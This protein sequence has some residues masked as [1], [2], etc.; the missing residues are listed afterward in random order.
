MLSAGVTSSIDQI[1]RSRKARAGAP[2]RT[3]EED[4][5]VNSIRRKKGSA[6][7][8][9]NSFLWPHSEECERDGCGCELAR[10]EDGYIQ[11]DEKISRELAKRRAELYA[12]GFAYRQWQMRM[13][14]EQRRK[15]YADCL[16]DAEAF[17]SEHWRIKEDG[18][19]HSGFATYI[20]AGV[21]LWLAFLRAQHPRSFQVE[22]FE[23][24]REDYLNNR[25][26]RTQWLVEQIKGN[27]QMTFSELVIDIIRRLLLNGDYFIADHRGE[28]LENRDDLPV[29]MIDLGYA[30]NGNGNYRQKKMI[31]GYLSIN[32][33]FISFQSEDFYR[34]LLTQAQGEGHR[35]P[36]KNT[37]W[38][39]LCAG[40]LAIRPK[41][42]RRESGGHRFLTRIG[43][44]REQCIR[45]P[46]SKIWN[47]AGDGA[48]G[49]GNH[50]GDAG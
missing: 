17:V 26:A 33:Q 39:T 21:C 34:I 13:K 28:A 49:N 14:P 10:N 43:K 30:P 32:H 8:R 29:S 24:R 18:G 27:R 46:V 12:W 40:A 4:Y 25:L 16:K 36:L 23:A 42:D 31:L 2:V 41:T 48:E 19:L 44:K 3:G 7:F 45:I 20:I 15:V 1:A 35:I 38:E 50:E 47:I 22:W 37:A 5:A 6:E 9:A 11:S